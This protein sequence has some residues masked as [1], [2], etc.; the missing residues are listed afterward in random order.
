MRN[1]IKNNLKYAFLT[2]VAAATLSHST[3]AQDKKP[4]PAD[5]N[6]RVSGL[7]DGTSIYN[8]LAKGQAYILNSDSTLNNSLEYKVIT[9][10]EY[11]KRTNTAIKNATAIDNKWYNSW[12][13]PWAT[14]YKEKIK[15]E[16]KSLDLSQKSS[17]DKLS[18]ND[19]KIVEAGN[20]MLNNIDESTIKGKKVAT[21]G[22][23]GTED[24]KLI[25]LIQGELSKK[26][27]TSEG[28][29]VP[30]VEMRYSMIN[31]KKTKVAEVS[32]L[33]L[34]KGNDDYK[35]S[36]PKKTI[37][38]KQKEP[39]KDGI[40]NIVTASRK[41]TENRN[42]SQDK[43]NNGTNI[44]DSYNTI[45]IT[46]NQTQTAKKDSVI[47]VKKDTTLQEI[48]KTLQFYVSGGDELN[49][50]FKNNVSIAQFG[51]G[52]KKGNLSAGVI[53]GYKNS[54]EKYIEENFPNAQG[55]GGTTIKTNIKYKIMQPGVGAGLD[56]TKNIRACLEMQ[57]NIINSDTTGTVY[58]EVKDDAGNLRAMLIP[59][60]EKTARIEF[61]TLNP[62][63]ELKVKN[64]AV[65]AGGKF[66]LKP[67]YSDHTSL[68]VGV[69]LYFGKE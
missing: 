24:T 50:Y 11:V 9:Y 44:V 45:N 40:E 16:K 14:D 48:K 51:A 46:I 6:A 1:N 54:I 60:D 65:Y 15:D 23:T 25:Y 5:E 67:N 7:Y 42:N 19:S 37:P 56:I 34:Y 66:A 28:F 18:S 47:A 17:Y 57:Y 13:N 36:S 33:F 20:K 35:S 21:K 2:A 59:L 4:V 41:E 64:F 12:W 62:S 22:I 10:D 39:A 63:I 53:F 69:K 49:S 26:N 3:M 32:Q 68:N 27:A 31:G 52:F 61:F 8:R 58:Q 30:V 29:I 38:L 55:N 43:P